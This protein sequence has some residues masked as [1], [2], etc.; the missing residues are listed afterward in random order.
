MKF[1]IIV[2]VYNV[3]KYLS[4]CVQ[5]ILNQTFQDFEL[6]LVN[7]GS[8][9][10]CPALCD[11]Y[12]VEDSRVSVIHK[13]NGGLSSAR[14]SGLASAKGEY[15]IF[16]DSDDYWC[17]NDALLSIYDKLEKTNADILI[18]GMKKYYQ[19]TDTFSEERVPVCDDAISS[20]AEAI[21][22][23]MKKNCF[24]ASAW[25][26]VI[27][28]RL[29]VS[30]NMRFVD[31]QLSEDIEWCS[32]LLLVNP[33]IVTLNKCIYVYRQQNSSSIT[34]N[35]ERRNLEHICD[36]IKRYSEIGRKENNLPILHFM[37]EQY[38][39]WLTTSYVVKK[40]EQKDLIFEMK[41]YW[42]LL[43]YNWYP[44]VSEVSRIKILKFDIVRCLLGLYK[45]LKD[46]R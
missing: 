16:I 11:S 43:E 32:K 8:L 18:F 17:C 40:K 44:H 28:H 13:Q 26:K 22:D 9:D 37:A 12:A 42:Y 45:K 23:M 35:I 25:D 1:S 21:K 31:G 3:E 20:N 34:A 6:I 4:Q 33:N 14:N 27:R 29:I 41:K 19:N 39:L 24:V 2:P 10:N 36:V 5:S 46:K 15:I 7:D 30:S 38:V